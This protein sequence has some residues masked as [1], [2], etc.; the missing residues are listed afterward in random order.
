M[1]YEVD[2]IVEGG[3][4]ETV[5]LYSPEGVWEYAR[6]II[7]DLRDKG[8]EGSVYALFHPHHGDVEECYCSQY[9]LDHRPL[10]TTEERP[11]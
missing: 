11:R 1:Y 8:L 6:S 9:A 4:D 2:T 7:A 10:L 3:V 5:I